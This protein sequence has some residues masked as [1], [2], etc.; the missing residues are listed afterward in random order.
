MICNGGGKGDRRKWKG[1]GGR[2]EKDKGSD[3]YPMGLIFDIRS[4]D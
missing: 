2:E 1:G 4:G 3:I